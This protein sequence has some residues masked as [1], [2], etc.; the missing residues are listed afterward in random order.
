[1]KIE[2]NM[3]TTFRLN[4]NELDISFIEKLKKLFKNKEVSI[5]VVDKKPQT[6]QYEMY[7]KSEALKKNPPKVISKDINALI[8]EVNDNEI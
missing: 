3:Q 6:S 4:V 5:I 8:K 7:K 2:N 1:M